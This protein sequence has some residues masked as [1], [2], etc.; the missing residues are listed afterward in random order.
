MKYPNLGKEQIIKEIK[1]I[2]K[3][4]PPRV[5]LEDI[6]EWLPYPGNEPFPEGWSPEDIVVV[7]RQVGAVREGAE[8]KKYEIINKNKE[9]QGAGGFLVN[10]FDN[11]HEIIKNLD[12]HD[13]NIRKSARRKGAQ[14][15]GILTDGYYGIPEKRLGKGDKYP[16]EYLDQDWAIV[17]T[18]WDHEY[19]DEKD[20]YYRADSVITIDP[21]RSQWNITGLDFS[22]VSFRMWEEGDTVRIYK[23]ERQKGIALY[24]MEN[25]NIP[26]STIGV[27]FAGSTESVF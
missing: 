2:N 23:G 3:D 13:Y 19:D 5:W 11:P 1:K 22:K 26:N 10:S 6:S 27:S 20:E 4:E 8:T 25:I 15:K 16:D 18:I 7:A 17:K 9:N 24:T 21:I 12:G 14:R